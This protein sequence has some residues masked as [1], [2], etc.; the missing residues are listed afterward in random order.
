TKGIAMAATKHYRVRDGAVLAHAGDELRGGVTVELLPHV[1]YEVRHLVE[2]LGDDGQVRPWQTLSQEAIDAEL[3]AA[4]PHERISL[5]DAAIAAKQGDLA[6]LQDLR[7][8]ELRANEATD[9][10]SEPKPPKADTKAP[11]KA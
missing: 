2:P 7:L 1:A 3:A 11:A 9:K 10:S 8:R 6:K 5:I 4:R